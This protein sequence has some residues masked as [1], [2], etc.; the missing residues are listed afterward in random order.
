MANHTQREPRSGFPTFGLPRQES[1]ATSGRG[2]LGFDSSNNPQLLDDAGNVKALLKSTTG[3]VEFV[4]VAIPA[5]GA[6]TG[7][8]SSTANPFGVDVIIVNRVLR[9]TTQS[10]GAATVDIGVAA[11]ATTSNDGLIDGASVASAGLVSANGSNGS[12]YQ[13]WGA[14]QFLNIAEASGDV[15]ALVGSLYVAVVRA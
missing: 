4:E 12:S 8:F 5:Q 10:S 13:V 9:V 6:V 11:D 14:S 2:G 3:I 15:T 1:S 7:V